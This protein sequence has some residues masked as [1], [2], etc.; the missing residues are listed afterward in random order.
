MPAGRLERNTLLTGASLNTASDRPQRKGHRKLIHFN[1]CFCLPRKQLNKTNACSRILDHGV[2]D[3]FIGNRKQQ[4]L[5]RDPRPRVVACQDP[6][7]HLE[8]HVYIISVCLLQTTMFVCD[9]FKCAY[10]QFPC[11]H[12]GRT[13]IC[14]YIDFPLYRL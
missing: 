14:A 6:Y 12:V 3:I 8:F 7:I 2:A 4:N 11:G 13:R 1:R 10:L 5:R 9:V